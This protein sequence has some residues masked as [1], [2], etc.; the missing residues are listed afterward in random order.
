MATSMGTK[1]ELARV[2]DII[3]REGEHRG[4]TLSRTA[5]VQ[6][7]SV[8]KS[9]VWSPMDGVGETEQDPLLKRHPQGV[10]GAILYFIVYIIVLCGR[11]GG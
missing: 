10:A 9:V 5:T 2:V 6:S 3:V 1:E 8:P 7:P 11:C 4:L